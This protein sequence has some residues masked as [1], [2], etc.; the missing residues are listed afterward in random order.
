[1]IHDDST[2]W[3]SDCE[4][5]NFSAPGSEMLVA[6]VDSGSCGVDI[7]LMDLRLRAPGKRCILQPFIFYMAALSFDITGLDTESNA[8]AGKISTAP[9]PT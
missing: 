9:A 3:S 8:R 5:K 4:N 2:V 6:V 1:M 7:Q